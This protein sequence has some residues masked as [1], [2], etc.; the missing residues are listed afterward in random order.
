MQESSRDII[1]KYIFFIAFICISFFE[2]PIYGETLV[3]EVNQ[4]RS[5]KGNL[6]VYLWNNPDQYLMKSG[7]NYS[8]VVDLEKPENAPINGLIHVKIDDLNEGPYAMMVYHDEN[9]SYEFERNFVGI[10]MEGFAFGNNA[11]PNL[12]APKFQEA[13][14]NLTGAGVIQHIN[15]LY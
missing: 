15:I 7:A 2:K 4:L 6:M 1:M 8:L 3:L 14:I 11:R 10:P 12:G 13:A 5:L 9:R